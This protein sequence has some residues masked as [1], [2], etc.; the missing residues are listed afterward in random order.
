[1]SLRVL[2]LFCGVGGASEGYKRAGFDVVGVDIN[3]QPDYRAGIF[4][5]VDVMSLLTPHGLELMRQ[6]FDLIHASPPCQAYC[7]LTKGNNAKLGKEY[8]KLY[9]PVQEAL[10][11][12]G[13]P[14]VIENPAARPDVILCGEMFGLQVIRHR[15]FELGR[16]KAEQPAHIPHQGKTRTGRVRNDVG[17]YYFAVYGN[18]GS[19]GTVPEWKAAMG[20]TW[21]DN[22]KSIAEAIPPSYTTWI[23]EAFLRQRPDHLV[24]N[25]EAEPFSAG[26]PR[27]TVGTSAYSNCFLPTIRP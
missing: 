13:L 18:G 8:P 1:M 14:Y 23:G 3:P 27:Q 11:A 20:V 24:W 17:A 2:D 25:S 16:W 5:Q 12:S 6:N 10:E 9:E 4:W 22:R 7:D 19:K 26:F 21:T 15:K